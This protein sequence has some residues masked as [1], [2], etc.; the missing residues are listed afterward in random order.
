MVA[1]DYHSFKFAAQKTCSSPECNH[2]FPS[3]LRFSEKRNEQKLHIK[4]NSSQIKAG[5]F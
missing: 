1:N 3:K 4:S 2:D 5:K